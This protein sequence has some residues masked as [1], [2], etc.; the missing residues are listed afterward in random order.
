MIQE[1]E[2][3][4]QKVLNTDE[5]QFKQ[6][7]LSL[8]EYEY[9]PEKI[10]S[11]RSSKN[12]RISKSKSLID[13]IPSTKFN[14][15][16]N[17]QADLVPSTN[18]HKLRRQ[19]V[20]QDRKLSTKKGYLTSEECKAFRT[21]SMHETRKSSANTFAKISQEQDPTLNRTEAYKR[22]K[23]AANLNVDMKLAPV[24]K[25]ILIFNQKSKLLDRS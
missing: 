7:K 20:N 12:L 16:C 2:E 23:F 14:S 3:K 22:R 11:Y 4:T 13:I 8:A 10:A 21:S 18:N 24:N 5:K 25:E 17:Q 1:Y 9:L 19:D 15:K 6:S